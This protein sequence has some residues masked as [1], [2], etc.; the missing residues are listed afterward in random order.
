MDIQIK[1][2][3]NEIEIRKIINNINGHKSYFFKKIRET[4]IPSGIQK[5]VE[6]QWFWTLLKYK[7]L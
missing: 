2:E 1:T 6:K 7:N 3:I 4:E 5:V